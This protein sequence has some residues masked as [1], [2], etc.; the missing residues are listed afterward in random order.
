MKMVTP[1]KTGSIKQKKLHLINFTALP[2]TQSMQRVHTQGISVQTPTKIVRS[3][4][5]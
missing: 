2:S 4:S 1:Q 3:Y 5:N